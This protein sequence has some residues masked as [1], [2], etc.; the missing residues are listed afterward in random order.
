MQTEFIEWENCLRI[1]TAEKLWHDF[2][3]NEKALP[4]N[5]R[6]YGRFVFDLS[7][8]AYGREIKDDM[9]SDES[10]PYYNNQ[11]FAER[12]S[13]W[14][15][16]FVPG[17]VLPLHREY[18]RSVS[19]VYLTKKLWSDSKSGYMEWHE[20]SEISSL[21]DEP[22]HKSLPRFNC[23]NYYINPNIDAEER[24]FNPWHRVH[25]NNSTFNRYSLQM[26]EP[27]KLDTKPGEIVDNMKMIEQGHLQALGWDKAIANYP[28]DHEIFDWSAWHPEILATWNKENADIIE[29]M[30]A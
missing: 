16:C 2:V 13:I 25:R 19:T 1:E 21:Y 5:H 4:W 20:S 24:I 9:I 7:D 11:H 6:G 14:I 17:G 28:E 8:S 26:F 30:T 10:S 22:Y 29:Y 3:K 15:Q 18:V 12:C 27:V 23:G